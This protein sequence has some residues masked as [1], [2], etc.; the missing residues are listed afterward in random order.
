MSANSVFIHP[1]AE[2]NP[3]AS[4][5]DGSKIWNGVQVRERAVIGRECSLGK[6]TY[7]D[8]DVRIGDRV[9]IQNRVSI[10]KGVQLGD[11]VYVGPHVCFTNDLYPR[12]FNRHW[13]L[14]NTFVETGASLG[15]GATILCGVR[16][17][18]YALVGIGAVVTRDVPPHAL[19]TGNPAR[20]R[21]YV[22]RCGQPVPGVDALKQ[23][24]QGCPH[25]ADVPRA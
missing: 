8:L 21:G 10:F 13:Q 17:G 22:C 1:T 7:V 25:G 5:G 24:L 23:V 14:T 11:D 16:I 4:I 20:L 2:V 3:S 12:A 19:V 15:A 9:R 6:D 18:A